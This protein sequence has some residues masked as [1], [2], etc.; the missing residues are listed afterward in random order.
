MQS[1]GLCEPGGLPSRRP[2]SNLI[3]LR[4]HNRA[5]APRRLLA[6][7]TALAIVV[8]GIL[9]IKH[10]RHHIWPR[11]LA[12]V[13]PG[14]LY[15][16]GYC[17]PG[18]LTDVIQTYKIKTILTLLSDE[19][20]TPDQTKEETVA[21]RENVTILR[22]GMP[23]DG[24]GEFA[25]FDAAADAMADASKQP[26]LVHCWAGVNRTGAAC[27]AYR[28]KY[29]GWTIDRALA[30]AKANGY[31]PNDNP[32]LAEHLRAYAQYLKAPM[33]S[34]ASSQAG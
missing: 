13:E 9:A 33:T 1:A 28:L 27:V 11:R 15:R 24:R 5:S 4:A 16:A 31:S 22:I 34:L 26:M 18:P 6:I 3:M 32:K 17:E 25:Q 23:G 7:V 30:E 21:G 19:P 12:E 10:G 8:G 20:G 29:C 2:P 14:R